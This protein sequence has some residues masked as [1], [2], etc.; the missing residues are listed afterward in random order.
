MT[1]SIRYYGDPVLRKRAQEVTIFD[2]EIKRFIAGLVR[3]MYANPAA[4]LAAPQVGKSLRIFVRRNCLIDEEGN[5]KYTDEQVFV[6]PRITILDDELQEEE[7]GCL[8]LPGI[9]EEVVRPMRIRVEA[10]DGEGTPFTE[11]LEGYRARVIMHEN[12]HINGVLFVDR[13]DP[14]ARKKIEPILRALKKKHE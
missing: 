11:E 1:Y 10:L 13:I 7:E 5:I 4:G 14:K 12:D 8:S 2:E 6:N 3:T 9:R